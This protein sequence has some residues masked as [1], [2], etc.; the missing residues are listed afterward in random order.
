MPSHS[1][2]KTKSAERNYRVVAVSR[3]GKRT[4]ISQHIS[5]LAAEQA[6]TLVA[7]EEGVEIRIESA[8]GTA[9]I[10]ADE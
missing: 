8:V 10:R 4:T 3:D 2:P 5:F 7:S 6:R 1:N 9:P